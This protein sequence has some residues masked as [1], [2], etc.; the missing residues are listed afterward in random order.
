MLSKM[1]LRLKA[2]A[3]LAATILTVISCRREEVP[4]L[5]P[6]AAPPKRAES[7]VAAAAPASPVTVPREEARPIQDLLPVAPDDSSLRFPVQ[8]ELTSAVHLYQMD[9][10]KLPEDFAAL[11]KEKYLKSMPQPP[12]GKRFGLDRRRLQV[13]ILDN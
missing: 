7:P 4:P 11:V 2:V 13:V 8:K 6:T 3:F 10:Q 1:E 5:P 9:H 12:P